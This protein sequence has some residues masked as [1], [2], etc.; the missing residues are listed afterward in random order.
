MLQNDYDSSTGD[1][2]G[3]LFARLTLRGKKNV[4]KAAAVVAAVIVSLVFLSQV[5]VVV[6]F[7]NA[8]VVV[9]KETYEQNTFTGRPE[10]ANDFL[11]PARIP[12]VESVAVASVGPVTTSVEVSQTTNPPD[13]APSGAEKQEKAGNPSTRT[14]DGVPGIEFGDRRRL[15]KAH[16]DFERT[17]LRWEIEQVSAS[18][19]WSKLP[20]CPADTHTHELLNN[21]DN[22]HE[23]LCQ[24]DQ[25]TTGNGAKSK[26]QRWTNTKISNGDKKWRIWLAENVSLTGNL[27]MTADCTLNGNLISQQEASIEWTHYKAVKEMTEKLAPKP[28]SLDG[29]CTEWVEHPVLILDSYD[30]NNPYHFIEDFSAVFPSMALLQPFLETDDVQ[31]ILP[32]PDERELKG[33]PFPLV[34]IILA[35]IVKNKYPLIETWRKGIPPGTCFRKVGW[36]TLAPELY[37]INMHGGIGTPQECSSP[38][39]R[40]MTD[41]IRTAMHLP[42][43][44]RPAQ[45]YVMYAARDPVHQPGISHWQAARL[46]QNQEALL[47]RLEKYCKEKGMKF[48]A[49]RFY[50][51]TDPVSI[52]EQIH[53][54]G[55][56]DILMGVHGA[57]LALEAYL[58]RKSVMYELHLG[59]RG[60]F[61]YVDIS[62]FMGNGYFSIDIGNP[63]DEEQVIDGLKDAVDIW[64]GMQ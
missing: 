53:E 42:Q 15:H 18:K 34:D 59:S 12:F 24:S 64:R 44:D 48:H 47:V 60:N 56:A 10:I 22:G 32:R 54:V 6:T 31:V 43:H 26:I 2:G 58:P 49:L 33:P 52:R 28:G 21:F 25:K 29:K 57:G 36:I 19:E 11:L 16:G 63:A 5:K 4:A 3:L 61:H 40:A 35:A 45:P 39:W 1:N 9:H 46:L 30:W 51:T 27:E 55:R 23:I 20:R 17:S 38:L 41:Y 62:A 8:T 50:N 14:H 13:I 37:S 7:G